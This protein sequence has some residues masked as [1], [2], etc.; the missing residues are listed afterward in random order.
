MN[1]LQA[2]Q[3]ILD[4]VGG[5][6]NIQAFTNCM[7]R[8][9]ID[10]IDK[11]KI[12][13]NAIKKLDGVL[14]VVTGEQF[15]IIVGPGHA[16]RLRDAFAQISGIAPGEEVDAQVRDVAKETRD[17]IKAKHTTSVHAAFKHVANIF[18]PLIPGFIGCGLIIAIT[19]ILKTF[20]P[21]MTA[22]PWFNLFSGMGSIMGGLLAVLVGYN[23]AREF[24]GS[25]VLGA[26]AGAL[27]YIPQLN[28]IA[29]TAQ[30]LVV[31]IIGTTLKVGYGGIIGV[32]FAALV[33]A[34]I[35]KRVRKVIPAALDLFLVPLI[36]ILLGSLITFVVIMPLSALLMEGITYVLIDFALKQGGIIGGYI[37]SATFLPLVMLGIHQGLVPIHAQLIADHGY[38]VLLPI[39]AQAGAGQVGMAM[40]VYIKTKDKKLKHIISSALPIGFLGIGEPL[41]YG[42]SLPLF[43]PFITACLGAGFGGA[44]IAFITSNV[45]DVGANAFGLSGLLMIPIIADNMWIWYLLG[46]IVSYIGGFVL[47]YLFGYKEEY[48]ERLK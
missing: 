40:A 1:Y 10:V 9:R 46:L 7:T 2:A 5:K 27:I 36:T 31:P 29:A 42:V 11:S 23:S 16:Q 37:L 6:Q 26:I 19:N 32:L 35:E 4:L 21:A 34:A 8:L 45:G 44:L 18:I 22:N 24:G 43:Y 38:T 33:F 39:L 20:D 12:D 48:A 13:S 25:A 30:S 3:Q 47:T 14:G 41:I 17:A 28:G 15:Q